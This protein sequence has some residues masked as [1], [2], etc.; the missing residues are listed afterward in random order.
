MKCEK[1]KIKI[2]DHEIYTDFYYCDRCEET[3]YIKNSHRERSKRED[4][5]CLYCIQFKK[6]K[7]GPMFCACPSKL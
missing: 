4:A 6:T 7:K 3:F 1:C 5:K 2:E